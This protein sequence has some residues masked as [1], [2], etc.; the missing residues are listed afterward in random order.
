MKKKILIY[1]ILITVFLTLSLLVK[2]YQ[3]GWPDI[4]SAIGIVAISLVFLIQLIRPMQ[5]LVGLHPYRF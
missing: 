1:S 2:R 4:S 5:H 3:Y